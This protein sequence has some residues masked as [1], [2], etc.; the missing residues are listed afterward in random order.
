MPFRNSRFTFQ[1]SQTTMHFN[2]AGEYQN[3]AQFRSIQCNWREYCTQLLT[4]YFIKPSCTQLI[5]LESL[6]PIIISILDNTPMFHHF[7][8]F[9]ANDVYF[10]IDPLT[11]HNLID[12]FTSMYQNHFYIKHIRSKYATRNPNHPPT[13]VLYTIAGVLFHFITKI[14]EV[15]LSNLANSSLNLHSNSTETQQKTLLC[16][17]LNYRYITR[18][19]SHLSSSMG[20]KLK[21]NSLR[22][23]IKLL[24]LNKKTKLNHL[25]CFSGLHTIHRLHVHFKP[26]IQHRLMD[27]YHNIYR[28]YTVFEGVQ[29][30]SN[31]KW[32]SLSLSFLELLQS[33][34]DI[35]SI[36]LK[37]K[38]MVEKC[39]LFILGS[40]YVYFTCLC[41]YIYT[42]NTINAYIFGQLKLLSHELCVGVTLPYHRIGE[43]VIPNFTV[44]YRQ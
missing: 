34:S 36:L 30:C 10:N 9:S 16:S 23:V 7:S 24:S 2:N 8:L 22:K 13:Y 17:L 18:Y 6:Q 28:H 27:T 32:T 1:L 3:D 43:K 31:I 4:I 35:V 29:S 39:I 5:H 21:M 33:S 41:K 14:P 25:H 37:T 15:L 20:R 38:N 26:F 11:V 19:L 42:T 40:S 12:N 44:N